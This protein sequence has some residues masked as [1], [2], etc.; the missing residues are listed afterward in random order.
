VIVLEQVQDQL[1][2]KWPLAQHLQVA[3]DMGRFNGAF[4]G[5][6]PPESW[7]SRR[8]IQQDVERFGARIMT[9]TDFLDH[10][11]L[12]EWLHPAKINLQHRLWN[13][14]ES[15]FA[16]L[17]SL[18]Q[19]LCHLDAFRRNCF[20]TPQG[21]VAIDWSFVGEGPIGADFSALFWVN[22]IF[23]EID[24]QDA[25]GTAEKL[26]QAYLNG[27]QDAGWQGDPLVAR[28]GCVIALALRQL[29]GIGIQV[30]EIH[31][32]MQQGQPPHETH[33]WHMQR[34]GQVID[35]WC[36]QILFP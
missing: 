15:L 6:V 1:W 29:A 36:A 2:G 10:P 17:D 11:W 3:R 4:G 33:I 8:W 20:V 22:A 32:A 13:V 34:A 5:A 24:L 9:I 23:Q 7:L 16:Q 21:T 19:T 30:Y 35:E 31:A 14:R 18:P 26:L 27:L 28:R 25:A 12:R